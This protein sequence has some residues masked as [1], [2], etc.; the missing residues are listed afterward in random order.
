MNDSTLI[1]DNGTSMLIHDRKTLLSLLQYGVWNNCIG[2]NRCR[3][4]FADSGGHEDIAA[5]VGRRLTTSVSTQLGNDIPLL[6]GRTGSYKL[7][8]WHSSFSCQNHSKNVSSHL[9]KT[10]TALSPYGIHGL[11]RRDLRNLDPWS[12]E[13]RS[14]STSI[15]QATSV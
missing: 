11:H 7:K 2:C 15:V 4:I 14:D 13:Q 9:S 6:V 12:F 10:T 8:S 1:L 5:R 3:S